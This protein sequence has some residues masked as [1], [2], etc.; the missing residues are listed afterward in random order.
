MTI[1]LAAAFFLIAVLY[2]LVGQ[3]GGTGYV[4]VMGLAGLAPHVVKPTALVLNIVVSGIGTTRFARAGLLH[5]KQCVP[6]IFLGAPFSILGGALHVPA[7]I[8]NPL[9]GMLLIAAAVLL[10]VRRPQEPG[11]W[12]PAPF[13][14]ALGVGALIGFVSGITGVGGGIFLAPL[15]IVLGW[16]PTI[17]EAAA[18]SAL[19]N[20]INSVAALAGAWI[21]IRFLPAGTPWWLLAVAAGGLIGA[22]LSTKRLPAFALRLALASVLVGAG[23]RLLVS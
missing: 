17:R 1:A 4:A 2:A 22:G 18:V 23:V 13:V 3:A 16:T 8:Y 14:P 19:F 7:H 9:V 11:A 21:L 6:F 20:L 10:L 15:L 12:R 5:R